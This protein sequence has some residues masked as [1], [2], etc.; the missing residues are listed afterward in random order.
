MSLVKQVP[1]GQTGIKISPIIVG[2]MS[3]GDLKWQ[4]WTIENEDKVFEILKYAYDHGLRTF[5][6]ADVYSNG[7]SERL[8]GKFLKKYNI[9]RETVVIMTKVFFPVDE[10]M[11]VTYET[12][13]KGLDTAEG[14]QLANQRGLSRKHIIAGVRNSVE[15]LGTYIDVLQIHRLDHD[16]PVKEIMKTL[17]WVVEQGYTRY[18]GASTMRAT[19]FVELQMIADKYNWFQFVNLQTQYNLLYREDERDLIPFAKRHGL[20][21]TPWS[22][23]AG[24]QL[25]R[26]VSKQKDTERGSKDAF[27]LPMTDANVEIINRVEK[28]AKKYNVSMAIVSTAWVLS[29]GF[30]PIVGINS[31]KRVEDAIEASMIQLS[32]DDIKYLEEPYK[33]S[34]YLLY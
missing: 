30:Y 11:Q 8:L 3:F 12:M 34:E 9:K 22:P 31:I 6:T 5:D 15:R 19:E 17:N 32:E 23:N 2:C 26:P 27:F 14:I 24:G 18:I 10:D 1:F 21:M 7:K 29:K 33:P 13:N 20:A 25:T 28:I 4:S 16:T